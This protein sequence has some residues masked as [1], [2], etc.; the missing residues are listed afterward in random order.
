MFLLTRLTTGGGAEVQAIQLALR[1]KARGWSVLVVSMQ[2]SY[3]VTR[4]LE[5]HGVPTITLGAR[6]KFEACLFLPR[7]ARIIRQQRPHIMHSH[8][9]YAILLA[10]AVRLLRSMPVSIATLHGLKMYNVGGTGWRIREFVAGLTDR[11]SDVTSTVCSAAARHYLASRAISRRRL[12]LIP[13]G[14]DTNIF[15]AD[16]AM[17]GRVRTR[18]GIGDEFTWLLVGRFQPVKDHCTMLRAF[19]RVCAVDSS[20]LLLLVG[21]GPLQTE[22][23]ELTQAL[24]IAQRVRFLGRQTDVPALMNGADACV[25]SSRYE[26]LPMVLL[27]AAASG[28]PAVATDVG[29]T[30]DVVLE[31]VTG[32]LAPAGEP[33]ALAHAMLRLASLPEADRRA[34]GTRA[35]DH[36]I[37]N[38]Q[39]DPIIDRWEDLYFELLERKGVCP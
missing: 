16:P 6:N 20:S 14:I 25:L 27:E 10:R 18:L 37:E 11:L 23:M 26:A 3:E 7:L 38:F 35:R 8:M 36:V 21:S 32:F 9:S 29:G 19:A 33:Q 30:S 39:F 13:N 22:M 12:R 34:M 17:R 15:R 2:A 31:G 5:Q 28:L 4:I 1:L 24:G